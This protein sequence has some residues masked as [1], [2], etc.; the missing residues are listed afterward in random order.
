[1][2]CEITLMIFSNACQKYIP[3][4]KKVYHLKASFIRVD[5]EY[6]QKEIEIMSFVLIVIRYG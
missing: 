2:E 4:S 3:V 1:M 6:L 5:E